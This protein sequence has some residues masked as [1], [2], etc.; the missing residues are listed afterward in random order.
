[1][2]A[3]LVMLGYDV[4]NMREPFEPL[5]DEAL[6]TLRNKVLRNLTLAY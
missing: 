5:N 4:G 2:K 1:M 6:N 3:L